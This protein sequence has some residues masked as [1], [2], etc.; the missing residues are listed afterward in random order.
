MEWHQ[1]YAIEIYTL[2]FTSP[3]VSRLKSAG[4][5]IISIKTF[6]LLLFVKFYITGKSLS[7]IK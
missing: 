3:H 6:V 5:L 2:I 4:I 1:E 7:I